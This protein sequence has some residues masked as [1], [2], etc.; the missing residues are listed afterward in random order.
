MLSFED[1]DHLPRRE[2]P[3]IYTLVSAP[4][5]LVLCGRPLRRWLQPG[6]PG[7]KPFA[8]WDLPCKESNKQDAAAFIFRVGEFTMHYINEVLVRY[9]SNSVLI[10]KSLPK[11]FRK[12]EPT[13]LSAPIP[14]NTIRLTIT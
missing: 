4:T 12:V 3:E 9:E 8:A 2:S 11:D 7:H 10:R 5:D 14:R 6:T 1:L 13:D